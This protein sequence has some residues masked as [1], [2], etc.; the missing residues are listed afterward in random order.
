MPASVLT[1]QTALRVL[2]VDPPDGA[3]TGP[4]PVF[5]VGYGGI[6]DAD[7]RRARFRIALSEDGFRSEAYVVDQLERRTGWLPGGAGSMLYRP[8]R[9]LRDGTYEWRVSVWDGVG[10][11]EGQRTFSLRVDT[12]PPAAVEGLRLHLDRTNGTVGLTWDPVVLDRRGGPEF[13]SRYHVYRYTRGPPFPVAR[14]LRAGSTPTP[15]WNETA[16]A[17]GARLVLYRVT[18]EDEAGNEPLRRE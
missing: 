17:P 3:V 5:S 10:W 4:R 2:P 13:V 15:A 14:P 18:A 1:A 6:D 8:R 12:V 7:L 9:P 11:Q 16:T